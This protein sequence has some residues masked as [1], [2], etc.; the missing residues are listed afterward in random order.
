V[1]SL[2][3]PTIYL[4]L[5]FSLLSVL[6]PNRGLALEK[7]ELFF[8][9]A[10]SFLKSGQYQEAIQ[11]FSKAIGVLALNNDF[12]R[13]ALLARAQA[14]YQKGDTKNAWKDLREVFNYPGLSGELLASSLN[15]RALLSLREG[16]LSRAVEDYSTAVITPHSNQSLKS[17]TFANRGITYL[18]MG[19]FGKAILD[20]DRAIEFDPKSGFNYAAR[21]VAN[22]RTDKVEQAK[23]DSETA[24][25]LGP[26]NQ[27]W[28]LASSVLSE[29]SFQKIDQD[30][31]VAKINEDGQI[32][33][34]LKFGKNGRPHRFLLDTGATHSLIDKSLL[35][36]L[37]RETRIKEIG[38]GIVHLADGSTAPVTR[39]SVESAFLYQM[40]LGPIQ[41]Q[42][43]DKKNKRSLNLL[44]AGSLKNLSILIDTSKKRVEIRRKSS[45]ESSNQR[46][47]NSTTR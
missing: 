13:T 25:T 8:E 46:F 36:E 43:M 28:R 33:V 40:P 12:A 3:S 39:Y 22:L 17:V 9:E 19:L 42:T 11:S 7:Q 31:I 6:F 34:Q 14:Y 32:F 10:K 5:I 26:D 44:G 4:V 27:T 24:M 2:I 30:C 38:K 15:L 47:T 23:K 16:K 21:A 18:N 29:L 1:Y 41:V 35:K 20:F 45:S 37:S